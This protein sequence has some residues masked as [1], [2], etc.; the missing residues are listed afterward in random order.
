ME[1]C[2]CSGSGETR[3]VLACAGG[4]N[5]GQISNEVARRLDTA[6]AATFACLAG[7]SGGIDGITA[8]V[9]GAGK[10]LVVD[11]CPMACAKKTMDA[12]GI[13]GYR[14]AVVTDAGIKKV[15]S[16][17]VEETDIVKA[18]AICLEK[19]QG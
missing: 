7:I 15:H 4:S 18:V 13:S 8:S 3:I 10:V 2:T 17:Q 19:L 9:K 6:G 11:G 5:V 1:K 14:Y 12:A 16:F